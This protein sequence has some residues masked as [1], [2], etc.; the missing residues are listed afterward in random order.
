MPTTTRQF[1]FDRPDA[2]TQP[3]EYA[4]LRAEAPLTRVMMVDGTPAWLATRYDDVALIL[5]DPRFGLSPPGVC[6]SNDSLFQDGAA[7]DRLRRLVARAFTARNIEALRPRVQR[8]ARQYVEEMVATGPPA[9]L[10]A[11]LAQ[12]LPI[13]VIA[14][15]LGV[16]LED[17]NRFRQWADA[18]VALVAPFGEDTPEDTGQAWVA[19]GGYVTEL[20]ATK[21]AAPGEDLLSALIAVRDTDDGR[22]SDNELVTMASA[23][24]IAGSLTTTN[25]ISIGVLK[26]LPAH[27]LGG[28]AA[29]SEQLRAAVEEV[30]RHQS[31]RTGEAMPR[32]AH[33]D[34]ELQGQRI[35]AGDMVLARIEAANRDPD[36]FTAPPPVQS[37]PG[38]EP[39]PG[40]WVRAAPLPRRDARSHR[41][42]GRDRCP[43]RSVARAAPGHPHRRRGVD[44]QPPR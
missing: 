14:E 40:V 35:A 39:A 17:R 38:P 36:R 30:L 20:V 43:G 42:A 5:S 22:L 23:L 29:V 31:G 41:T 1:P 11:G 15:L 26:L 44:R 28:L 32:F 34:I 12:P 27:R 33:E 25:A 24:L 18:V 10:V 3:P 6:P 21:R 7:H 2:L 13:T 16:G 4:R 9:D 37:R 8:L 19:V